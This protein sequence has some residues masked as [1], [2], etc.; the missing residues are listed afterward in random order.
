MDDNSDT[1]K[2]VEV[3]DKK[4]S[5]TKI[6]DGFLRFW[7]AIEKP[8]N[9]VTKVLRC[10]L[11]AEYYI[12]KLLV[13]AL[14]RGDMFSDDSCRFMFFEKLFVVESLNILN[15]QLIDSLKNLNKLRN[16]CSHEQDFDI[17]EGRIDKIGNPF[18]ID[19]LTMKKSTKG[20]KDLLCN[21]LMMVIARLEGQI[22]RYI[23]DN[24]KD[25]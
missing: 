20:K 7:N 22:D 19:Y 13:A 25:V 15:K 6:D 14:P 16:D 21:T 2:I 3:L 12:D 5:R 8:N 4:K 11:L 23:E 9:L 1:K 10:H 17:L 18:G 24:K